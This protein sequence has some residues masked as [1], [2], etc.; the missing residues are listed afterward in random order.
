MTT[1]LLTRSFLR[2]T[3]TLELFSYIGLNEPDALV[4][5][6]LLYDFA[7]G[8]QIQFGAN[9]FFGDEGRFGRF[10]KNDMVYLKTQFSF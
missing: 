3:L 1:V 8:F 7:D 4:R 10:D 2:E 6:G 9:I 5:P